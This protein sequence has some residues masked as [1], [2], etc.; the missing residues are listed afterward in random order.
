MDRGGTKQRFRRAHYVLVHLASCLEHYASDL[1]HVAGKKVRHS[2]LMF[3]SLIT[4]LH[5]S[6]SA[7]MN[8]LNSS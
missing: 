4:R 8:C 6:I 5:F 1:R 7:W 3:A 2:S